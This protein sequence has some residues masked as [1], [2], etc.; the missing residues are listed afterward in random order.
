MPDIINVISETP[1]IFKGLNID[2]VF[3]PPSVLITNMKKANM[4]NGMLTIL[5]PLKINIVK[6]CFL[7]L[8][9]FKQSTPFTEKYSTFFLISSLFLFLLFFN[10]HHSI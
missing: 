5:T 8:S 4:K 3:M 7:T 2:I 10:F 9:F 6:R 1:N